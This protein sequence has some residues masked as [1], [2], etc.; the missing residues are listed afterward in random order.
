MG[1][2][3]GGGEKLESEKRRVMRDGGK[4]RYWCYSG[5]YLNEEDKIQPLRLYI[6]IASIV[7]GPYNYCNVAVKVPV[8]DL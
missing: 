8:F 6:V 1:S 2:R 3:V 5:Y 7:P 4:V